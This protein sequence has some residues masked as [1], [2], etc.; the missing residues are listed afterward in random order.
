MYLLKSIFNPQPARD[1]PHHLTPTSPI[2]TLSN[3]STVYRGRLTQI[4]GESQFAGD[5]AIK[6]WKLLL[7]YQEQN[8]F[9]KRACSAGLILKSFARKRV[10]ANL[11][12]TWQEEA[13]KE[14]TAE[15]NQLKKSYNKHKWNELSP[16][17][18]LYLRK[19]KS[20]KKKHLIKKFRKLKNHHH[21][22]QKVKP[23]AGSKFKK[24]LDRSRY[25]KSESN[26]VLEA[27]KF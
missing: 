8:L 16:E 3:P 5:E 24:R 25:K 17:K 12:F 19:W 23:V 2:S 1:E 9:L 7:G 21:D 4:S 18:R 6:T 11:C 20:L 15:E 14:Q 27:A 13:L 26:K 22:W 10:P